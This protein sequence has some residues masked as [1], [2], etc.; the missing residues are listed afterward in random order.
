MP[1][2]PVNP[3]DIS[4]V[5]IRV[6]PLSPPPPFPPPS[7]VT[8]EGNAKITENQNRTGIIAGDRL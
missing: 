4:L 8:K 3:S 1:S 6:T 7:P 5:C 2:F